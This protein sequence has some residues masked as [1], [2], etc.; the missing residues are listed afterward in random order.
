MNTFCE[1]ETLLLSST[2]FL[3]N[4][5]EGERTTRLRFFWRKILRGK[6][7]A[8]TVKKYSPVQI[9]KSK[10]ISPSK[11]FKLGSEHRFSE[12]IHIGYVVIEWLL[13]FEGLHEFFITFLIGARHWNGRKIL[14]RFFA[15]RLIIDRSNFSTIDYRNNIDSKHH[16]F[17]KSMSEIPLLF[18]IYQL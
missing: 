18:I 11:V 17:H 12:E 16:Y 14:W 13:T 9:S 2:L 1:K 3:Q 4:L 6:K 5:T 10:S 15:F 8:A 7:V